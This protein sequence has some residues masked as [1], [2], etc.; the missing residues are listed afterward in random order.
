M[1]V[2][3][4]HNR[5]PST[6]EDLLPSELLRDN[7][8]VIIACKPSLWLIVF[9]SFRVVVIA[10][11]L[12]VCLLVLS[13]W[14]GLGR[15]TQVLQIGLGAVIVLRLVVGLLQWASRVYVLTD[16]RV[17]RIRGVF[18]IDIFQCER[19]KVQNTFLTLTLPQRILKLGSIGFTTAGT[20]GV[21][22]VWEHIKNPLAI[23]EQLNQAF[24]PTKLHPEVKS[25]TP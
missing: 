24:N 6:L 25:D 17:I 20:A 23:H 14:L 16:Q 2:S 1:S 9:F 19:S 10:L 3:E 22:A 4:S 11:V 8:T 7:E 18:T 13:P 15:V 5:N 21:E 12:A